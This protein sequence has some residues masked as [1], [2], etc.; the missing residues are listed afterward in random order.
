[1]LVSASHIDGLGRVQRWRGGL[2][3]QPQ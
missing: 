2:S 1:V 3:W